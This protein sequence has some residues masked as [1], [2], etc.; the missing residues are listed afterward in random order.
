MIERKFDYY[1]QKDN[2]SGTITLISFAPEPTPEDDWEC[3]YLLML[4][5]KSIE[6]KLIGVDSLQ[7]LLLA[8][9]TAKTLLMSY[10]NEHQLTIT[11]LEMD[12]IGLEL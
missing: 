3:N 6:G 8:L 9:K 5:G 7:A 12:N 11:W 1:S 4:P 10:A 2:S